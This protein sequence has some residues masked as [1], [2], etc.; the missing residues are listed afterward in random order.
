VFPVDFAVA[1]RELTGI[2]VFVETGTYQGDT[3]VA[4]AP[5]FA[6]VLSIE[7]CRERSETVLQR[8]GLPSNVE[9]W[10][11]D[12]ARWLGHVLRNVS[13]PAIVFLDAHWI[14]AGKEPDQDG[15]QAGLSY[16]PLCGELEAVREGDVV[17]IDDAHFFTHPPRARGE[18]DQWLSLDQ[19]IG[20]LPGR[21]VF[22]HEGMIC[23]V[24]ERLRV[25]MREWLQEN[26]RG[27]DRYIENRQE[28]GG[29]VREFELQDEGVLC[30]P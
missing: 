13:G 23:A 22:L 7:G 4:L 19:I 12:S 1:L 3:A 24:P 14:A 30:A 20:L 18:D 15:Y 8:E 5:H 29:S 16:C 10:C 21:Y 11:G 28:N 25:P 6:R 9:L 26:W 27:L 17:L 2:T